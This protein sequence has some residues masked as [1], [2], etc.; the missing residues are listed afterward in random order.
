M[1]KILLLGGSR[2][3]LP[4]IQS[5]HAL[6]VSVIT[7]DYLPDN[8]AHRYSDQYCNVSILDQE[9]VL[10][11]A[12]RL[13]VDGIM[14]F[15]CDPGV[16]TAA[17]VAEEMGLPSCGSYESVRILQNKARFRKFLA[18]NGF[19]VPNARCYRSGEEALDELSKGISVFRWPVIVKPVDSAGSKGVMRADS[20]EDLGRCVRHALSFSHSGE[21]IAEDFL[22]QAGCPSDSD[23]FSVDGKLRFVSFNDQRFDRNAENPY[24]PAAFSWPSSM[25]R[26]Y[27][28]ELRSELQRLLNLL[29]MKTSIYNVETRLCTDGRP[30]IMEVSPRGG[31]NRLSECLRYAAGVD[32]IEASVKAALGMPVEMEQ[33]SC[34]GY[35]AEAVL[36]SSRAGRFKGLRISDRLKKHV[37]EENVWIA[38]GEAV[39]PFSGANQSLGTVILRFGTKEEMEG[40]MNRLNEDIEVEIEGGGYLRNNICA[41]HM[42]EERRAA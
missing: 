27:Q 32:L 23:C 3:A 42:R 17:Y 14:S 2:Y 10:K 18:E 30:Y 34:S 4:V 16:V 22:E 5:A 36:H 28:D 40:A 24:T 19:C 6:G 26:E 21:C 29:H 11:M 39:R 7:C 1:K 31:G 15:A 9:A 8:I 20:P 33:K 38:P 13:S 41:S 37:I 25:G 12:R 35:W